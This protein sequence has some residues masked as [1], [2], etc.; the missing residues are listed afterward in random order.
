MFLGA[1]GAALALVAG[2]RP[3]GEAVT[4]AAQGAVPLT[5]QGRDVTGIP[6]ALAVVALAS[7]VAVFAVR[8]SGRTAVAAVMALCGAAIV[9]T[10][11]LGATD[12]SALEAEAAAATGLAGAGVREVAH[13][14][15]PWASA[16]GG[17]LLLAA[18][19]LALRHGRH[20]PAMSGR[21]ERPGQA[22]ATARRAPADPDRPEEIWKALDRG[23]D[24]TRDA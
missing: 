7:L 24:P 2:G 17:V 1:A 13:T 18:G 21:Y 6:A 12:T 22:G 3:W 5:A 14:V 8:R 10:S 15:W 23:E 9:V 4:S 19:L 11:V 20:W 16:A